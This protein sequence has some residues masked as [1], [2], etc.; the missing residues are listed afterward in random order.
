VITI[1]IVRFDNGGK[2]IFAEFEKY[3]LGKVHEFTNPHIPQ[4]NGI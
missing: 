1:R 3:L 2:F 4:Q